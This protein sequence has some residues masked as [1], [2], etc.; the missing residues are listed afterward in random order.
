M[1][2]LPKKIT[3]SKTETMHYDFLKTLSSSVQ[4]KFIEI[5]DQIDN[6]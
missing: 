3:V 5:L 1:M 4:S 6:F 2:Q